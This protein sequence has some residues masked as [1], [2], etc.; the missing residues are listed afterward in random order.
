MLAQR[1]PLA[2]SGAESPVRGALSQRARA[3]DSVEDDP[4]K[5]ACQAREVGTVA[6]LQARVLIKVNSRLPRQGRWLMR[7]RLA[8]RRWQSLKHLPFSAPAA[9]SP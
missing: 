5:G 8:C 3:Q 6:G 7:R 2:V 9:S 1:S 4:A